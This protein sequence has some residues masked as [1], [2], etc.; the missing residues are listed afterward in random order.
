[1]LPT[2]KRVC[3]IFWSSYTDSLT[4][5]TSAAPIAV[6]PT[7]GQIKPWTAAPFTA[8]IAT[9]ATTTATSTGASRTTTDVAT[10]TGNAV[11]TGHRGTTGGQHDECLN[12]PC[13]AVCDSSGGKFDDDG[14][15]FYCQPDTSCARGYP[16]YSDC[17]QV[18]TTGKAFTAPGA[19]NGDGKS[20][21]KAGQTGSGDDGDDQ[22]STLVAVII[23]LAV[24]FTVI[25]VVGGAWLAH[26]T[27][28]KTNASF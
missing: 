10:P 27:K 13:G 12:K 19:S 5:S 20:G 2:L 16:K 8:P 28:D 6:Q 23:I 24:V 25:M 22:S 3:E 11:N 4:T 14:V 18:T 9:A 1:M 26:T 17:T 7:A 21:E 15:S